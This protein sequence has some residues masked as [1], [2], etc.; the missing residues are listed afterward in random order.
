[1][2]RGLEE[3]GLAVIYLSSDACHGGAF[4]EGK[5]IRY[6]LRCAK[7]HAFDSWFQS[8]AAY[9]SLRAAGHLSCAV[10]GGTEV[11]KA[12][13][14]PGVATGAD[15][16]AP[17]DRPLS[18]PASPAEQFLADLRRRIEQGSED[19]GG[20]FAAEARAIHEGAA[21]QRAIR[22]EATIA[23]ARALIEDEIPVLPLPWR[24]RGDS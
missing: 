6:S 13:M 4:R 17:A 7:G 2:P 20:R 12:L 1:M 5:M 18:A 8:S 3:T 11:G 22:G 9:D 14:A 16:P 24:G 10:C 15:Q 19:V 23:D 21:P